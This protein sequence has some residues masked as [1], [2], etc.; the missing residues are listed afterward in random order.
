MHRKRKVEEKELVPLKEKEQK[1]ASES[2][3]WKRGSEKLVK[4]HAVLII[5]RRFT[6]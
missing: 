4:M 3:A 5:V 1:R 6:W 2:L